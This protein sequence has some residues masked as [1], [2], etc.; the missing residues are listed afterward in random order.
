MTY[1]KKQIQIQ[2]INILYHF[3]IPNL[4]FTN[5]YAMIMINM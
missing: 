1:I 3:I 2:N 5:M 4:T